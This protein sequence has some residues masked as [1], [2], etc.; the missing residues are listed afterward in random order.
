MNED[1]AAR[2]LRDAVDARMASVPDGDDASLDAIRA[3]VRTRRSSR[4]PVFVAV[5]AAAAV[6]VGVVI[7]LTRN[8]NNTHV[9]VPAGSSSSVEPTTSSSWPLAGAQNACREVEVSAAASNTPPPSADHVAIPAWPLPG[10]PPFPTPQEAA[11]SFARDYLGFGSPVAHGMASGAVDVTPNGDTGPHTMVGV[12]PVPG[13]WIVVDAT[14][15][16]VTADSP[17]DANRTLTV[18]GQSVAFEAQIVVQLRRFG[19]TI[20]VASTTAMGGTTELAPYEATLDATGPGLVVVYVPDPSGRGTA[21]AAS[22]VTAFAPTPDTSAFDGTIIAKST[23]G[24]YVNVTSA[25]GA[26]SDAATFAPM[27]PPLDPGLASI[28]TAFGSHPTLCST[29]KVAVVASDGHTVDAVDFFNHQKYTLFTAQHT[30]T[31]LD[32]NAL[33]GLIFTDDQTGLW[34]WDG[35]GHGPVLMTTGYVD[36]AW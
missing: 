13:G 30:I 31:S 18:G 29:T 8:D 25:G 14:S 22:V 9:I 21:L 1:D 17:A 19:S 35:P 5:A 27:A 24:S 6:L 12:D 7:V 10:Q 32:A 34:R 36:A 3:R 33:G 23:D 16:Q 4:V 26:P 20:A 2:R 11:T 28:M 15:D